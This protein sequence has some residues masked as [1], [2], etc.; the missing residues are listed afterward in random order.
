MAIFNS[1]VSHY[2]RVIYSKTSRRDLTGMMQIGFGE[3][4]RNI[5]L[6]SGERIPI[7]ISN[8]VGGLEHFLFFHIYILGIVTPTD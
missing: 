4:S 7:I 6:I 5:G 1:Y 3:L 2:Q 8:L